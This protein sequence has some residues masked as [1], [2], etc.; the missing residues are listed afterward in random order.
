MSISWSIMLRWSEKREACGDSGGA[1][2]IHSSDGTICNTIRRNKLLRLD[3]DGRVVRRR[4]FLK[5][6]QEKSLQIKLWNP[7][8]LGQ[9]KH[10]EEVAPVRWDQDWTSWVKCKQYVSWKTGA[11]RHHPHCE[12]WRWQHHAERLVKVDGKMDGAKYK[13]ISEK[14]LLD[15]KPGWSFIF[16]QDGNPKHTARDRMEWF[17]AKYIHVLEWPGVSSDLIQLTWKWFS[18]MFFIQSGWAWENVQKILQ[19]FFCNLFAKTFVNHTS[20]VFSLFFPSD[21]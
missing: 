8:C 5:Q 16:Q 21:R 7:V 19:N 9:S 6:S 2:E 15:L 12:V 1:S 13:P 14:S 11:A 17:G 3:L 10:V 4:L 20:E 18:Q